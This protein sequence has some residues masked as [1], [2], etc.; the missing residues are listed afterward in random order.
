M[1]MCLVCLSKD[2]H[3]EHGQ[4]SRHAHPPLM[5]S[6]MVTPGAYHDTLPQVSW[7]NPMLSLL[8]YDLLKHIKMELTTNEMNK[9]GPLKSITE[10]NWVF[11]HLAPSII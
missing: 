6:E 9:Q 8:G 10:I 4:C 3:S 5:E 11:F 2:P 7:C 1:C